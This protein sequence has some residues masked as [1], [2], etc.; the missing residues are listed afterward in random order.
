MRGQQGRENH[1]IMKIK[2]AMGNLSL[3]KQQKFNKTF[4]LIDNH[5]INPLFFNTASLCFN[6][7]LGSKKH[8]QKYLTAKV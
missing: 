4:I 5:S 7:F 2:E 8:M 1:V 6:N 3:I